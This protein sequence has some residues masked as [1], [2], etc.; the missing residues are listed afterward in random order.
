MFEIYKKVENLV[1]LWNKLE[2]EKQFN[3]KVD[4]NLE[5]RKKLEEAKNQGVKFIDNWQSW[6]YKNYEVIEVKDIYVNEV[7]LATRLCYVLKNH[8]LR[9]ILV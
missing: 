1:E 6:N 4:I 5:L 2:K 9:Y 8:E 7:K 3:R